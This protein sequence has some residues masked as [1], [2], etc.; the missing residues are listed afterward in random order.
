MPDEVVPPVQTTTDEKLQ[1]ILNHMERMDK[2]DKLRTYGGF[3]RNAITVTPV[4]IFLFSAWYFYQ[5]GPELLQ[6]ITD[7]TVKS[8]A[9]QQQNGLMDQFNNYIG[10][11][12]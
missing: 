6:Q 2:R 11:P 9:Q 7:M 1:Q 4:L 3:I 10:K 12:K 5:H 8:A